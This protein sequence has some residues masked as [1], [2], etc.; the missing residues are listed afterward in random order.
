MALLDDVGIGA[1]NGDDPQK[2]IESVVKQTN[3]ALRQI[4]NEDRTKIIKDDSGTPRYLQGFQDGGFE[5]GNVGLKVSQQGVDVTTATSDQLIWSTDFNNFKIV[6]TGTITLPFAAD[7]AS[8]VVTV[9]HGQAEAPI[10]YGFITYSDTGYTSPFPAI[11]VEASG[12]NAGKV[13][14]VISWYADSTNIYFYNQ[15]QLQGTAGGTVKYYII[16]ETAA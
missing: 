8:E 5:N 6:Q 14:Q 13:Y 2:Q 16:E 10:V 11:N 7:G 9:A 3:E 4:S 15:S 12:A 1:I